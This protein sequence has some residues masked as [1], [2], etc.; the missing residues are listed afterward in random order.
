M[1]VGCES[2]SR[3]GPDRV[4]ESATLV[5]IGKLARAGGSLRRFPRGVLRFGGDGVRDV[6]RGARPSP[7]QP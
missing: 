2:C 7:P 1:V 4:V 5:P 6:A 3:H